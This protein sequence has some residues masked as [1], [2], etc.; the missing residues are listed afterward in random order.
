I[1]V[2]NEGREQRKGTTY[3]YGAGL[4]AAMHGEARK[5]DRFDM[6]SLLRV[7]GTTN[8]PNAK[9][10]A[11][12]RE[13]EPVVLFALPG[14]AIAPEQVTEWLRAHPRPAGAAST[15]GNGAKP[16]RDGGNAT[17]G[18]LPA[19][20]EDWLARDA[21]LRERF[22]R[23]R[24][25]PKQTNMTASGFLLS[26]FNHLARKYRDRITDPEA[27]AIGVEFYR[28]AGETPRL[29]AIRRTWD[30]A[31][32]M[33]TNDYDTTDVGNARR[34]AEQHGDRIRYVDESKRWLI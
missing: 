22:E 33:K 1:R 23:T 2:T 7:P 28:R 24:P 6:A 10:R 3:A 4:N 12:G 20:W 16:Q 19:E 8:W 13:P 30:E 25:G 26:L 18:D 31:K 29:Q 17:P 9:K 15:R 32:T 14:G 34:F 27:L 21:I 11:K 5:V